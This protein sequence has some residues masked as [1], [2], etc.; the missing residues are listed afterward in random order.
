MTIS[1]TSISNCRMETGRLSS[2][3]RRRIAQVTARTGI[4]CTMPCTTFLPNRRQRPHSRTRKLSGDEKLAQRRR[5]LRRC[6][7]GQIMSARHRFGAHYV[8]RITLPDL[9]RRRLAVATDAAGCAPQQQHRALDLAAGLEILGVH[10]EID[11]EAGAIILAD[12]V[13]GFRIA[14]AALVFL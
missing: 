13:D 14:E 8:G 12:G 6:L 2:C 7:F 10:V 5:R 3:R 4:C 11:A 9:T 1:S